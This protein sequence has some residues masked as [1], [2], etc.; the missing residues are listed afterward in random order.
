[1]LGCLELSRVFHDNTG[2]GGSRTRSHTF[3]GTDNIHAIDNLSKDHVLSVEPVGLGGTQKEL[4]AV[5]VGSSVRH[6]KDT[7]TSVLQLKVLVSKLVSVDGLSTSTI[8]V[9]EV[10]TLAHESWDDTVKGRSLEA[11]ALLSGAK[12]TKVL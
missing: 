6:G 7:G 10:A 1:L 9:S 2:A 5:G 8:V 11:K 12:S 4:R 3:H